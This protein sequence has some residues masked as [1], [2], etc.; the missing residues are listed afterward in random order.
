MP[1][2]EEM[3]EKLTARLLHGRDIEI[4]LGGKKFAPR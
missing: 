2:N 1:S 3:A 4:S